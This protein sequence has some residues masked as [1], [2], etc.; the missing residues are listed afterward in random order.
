MLHRALSRIIC[1]GGFESHDTTIL[2]SRQALCSRVEC[3]RN[4]ASAKIWMHAHSFDPCFTISGNFFLPDWY[5]RLESINNVAACIECLCAMRAGDDDNDTGLANLQ[6]P[7]AMRYCDAFDSPALTN[8]INN[9]TDLLTCHFLVDFVLK[10]AYLFPSGI[11]AYHS[12]EYYNATCAWMAYCG[13][14]GVTVQGRGLLRFRSA[15]IWK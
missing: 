11:I 15:R 2:C 12:L 5:G 14:Q 6:V 9:F 3:A 10:V 13:N 1:G 7:K 8:F 4:A